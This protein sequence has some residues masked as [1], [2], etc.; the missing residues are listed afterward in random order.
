MLYCLFN[1]ITNIKISELSLFL[2]LAF[3]G[4]YERYFKTN[5]FITEYL[6]SIK[7]FSREIL[8]GNVL[9]CLG[10]TERNGVR[11]EPW[12]FPT[13]IFVED[14]LSSYFVSR[15]VQVL[16]TICSCTFTTL[17]L[18][19]YYKIRKSYSIYKF[20]INISYNPYNKSILLN[21][22]PEPLLCCC[23]PLNWAIME[24]IE[25][26]NGDKGALF[27]YKGAQCRWRACK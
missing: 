9:N 3:W 20:N 6:N 1:T 11:G 7:I 17:Q 14:E 27:L 4:Q 8:N 13:F 21:S 12:E 19:N 22:E 24:L 18:C 2:Q 16:Y 10:F 23:V 25:F 15:S 26:N 5:L